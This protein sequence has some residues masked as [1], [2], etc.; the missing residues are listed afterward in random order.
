MSATYVVVGIIPNAQKEILIAQRPVQKSYSGYWEFPGG[1]KELDET[2][3]ETLVREFKEELNIEVVAANPWRQ[4]EYQY[5]ERTIFLDIWIIT[6][7]KGEIQSLENQDFQWVSLS[8]LD[9]I[10]FLP[11]NKLILDDVAEFINGSA[12]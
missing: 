11:A 3:Y 10:H 12:C 9:N 2:P 1:K 8:K 6:E 5:P 4:M 7:F